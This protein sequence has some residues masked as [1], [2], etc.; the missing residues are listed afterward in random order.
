MKKLMALLVTVAIL[1]GL[2]AACAPTPEVVEK[3]VKETVVVEKEVEVE[4]T[5]EVEVVKEVVVMP[6]P[7]PG[8]EL[9]ERIPERDEFTAIVGPVFMYYLERYFL[10]VPDKT[11][12]EKTLFLVSINNR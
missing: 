2:V 7:E 10:D 1:A 4:V 11:E 3:V 8:V 9:T 12:T 5:K 6:T